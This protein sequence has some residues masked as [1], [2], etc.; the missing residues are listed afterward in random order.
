MWAEKVN[1]IETDLATARTEQAR[2][3]DQITS[4][5]K[6]MQHEAV[7]KS[8]EAVLLEEKKDVEA[9]SSANQDLCAAVEKAKIPTYIEEISKKMLHIS[10]FMMAHKWEEDGVPPYA[11]AH[12]RTLQ[13]RCQYYRSIH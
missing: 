7:I 8:K 2:L 6:A 12:S 10:Q 11:S 13:P 9:S 5:A 3:S 1:S 4:A